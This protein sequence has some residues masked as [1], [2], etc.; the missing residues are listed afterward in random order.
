MNNILIKGGIIMEE[1]TLETILE[2]IVI[3]ATVSITFCV[4]DS[5]LRRR[6]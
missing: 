4:L 1:I 2:T 6:Y 3:S 5:I